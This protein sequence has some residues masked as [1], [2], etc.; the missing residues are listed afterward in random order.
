MTL[1]AKERKKLNQKII[2]MKATAAIFSGY[3]VRIGDRGFMDLNAILTAYID[4]C[5][6]SLREGKD[7][8]EPGM[9]SSTGEERAALE[10]KL[11]SIFGTA[12]RIR[13]SRYVKARR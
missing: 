6:E 4:F 3:A 5:A 7:F 11:Q 8:T 12:C 2:E 13:I 10:A 9:L 1:D